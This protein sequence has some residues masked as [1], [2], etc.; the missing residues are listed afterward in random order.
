MFRF[1]SLF[2]LKFKLERLNSRRVAILRVGADNIVQDTAV[3]HQMDILATLARIQIVHP[4]SIEVDGVV[5][6]I[7]D[8]LATSVR[9][10]NAHQVNIEPPV[11]KLGVT[12]HVTKTR[13]MR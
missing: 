1:L 13:A 9:T 6:R 5:E 3:E 2:F 4:D 12:S 10:R 7:M 11:E 8:I